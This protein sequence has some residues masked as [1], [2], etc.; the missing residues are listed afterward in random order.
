MT[1]SIA[2]IKK[3]WSQYENKVYCEQFM[4]YAVRYCDHDPVGCDNGEDEHYDNV[5][6]PDDGT[7]FAHAPHD[8]HRLLSVI[9]N[10]HKEITDMQIEVSL[11][12]GGKEY[13]K[14]KAHFEDA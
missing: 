13:L 5:P 11:M 7:D 2:D 1:D 4:Y 3:R 14:A 6:H 10:L 8:I 9:D 12:P